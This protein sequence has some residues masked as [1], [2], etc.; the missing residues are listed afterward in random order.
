MGSARYKHFGQS[1]E[2]ARQAPNR[3]VSVIGHVCA[4]VKHCREMKI[5]SFSARDSLQHLKVSNVEWV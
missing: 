3:G 4:Q 2:R 5:G 1:R